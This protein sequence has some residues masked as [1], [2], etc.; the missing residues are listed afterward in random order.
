MKAGIV[1]DDYKLPIFRKRLE[2][3]GF[4]YEDGGEVFG[5]TLLR[6][7]FTAENFHKLRDTVEAC[8]RECKNLKRR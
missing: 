6:V 4:T 8:E 1:L 3:A 5:G 2:E 7:N